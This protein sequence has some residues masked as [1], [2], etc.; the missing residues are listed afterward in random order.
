MCACERD[1]AAHALTRADRW[2]AAG[3]IAVMALVTGLGLLWIVGAVALWRALRG[4]PGPGHVPTL[5]TYQGLVVALA[6]LARNVQ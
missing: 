5:L 2:L 4:E 3:T 6:L 1:G